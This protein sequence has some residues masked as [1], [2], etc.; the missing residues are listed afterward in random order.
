MLPLA[1][2]AVAIVPSQDVTLAWRLPAPSQQYVAQ[3]NASR[4]VSY[5]MNGVLRRLAGSRADPVTILEQRNRTLDA[6]SNGDGVYV[7]EVIL[8]RYGGEHPKDASV[9]KRSH[10][11]LVPAQAASRF[12][13]VGFSCGSQ[14]EEAGASPSP[15][16]TSTQAAAAAYVTC[17][18]A[19]D[20]QAQLYE[21]PGDAALAEFP[22]GP[23]K[24]GDSWTFSR[25]SRLERELAAGEVTYVDR[26]VRVEQRGDHRIAVL[27]VQATGRM[28]VV[29][30]LQARGFK[31]ATMAFKGIAEFDATSG[32]PQHQHYTGSTQWNTAILGAHLGLSIDETYDATPWALQN[33]P[34]KAQR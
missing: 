1:L 24:V 26:L 21:D 27:D 6:R 28:D 20:G 8:R 31:T 5:Q 16:A 7:A 17:A 15:A 10:R 11:E 23:I 25:R 13:P 3:S 9:K 12:S 19:K 30:D 32:V 4:T 2:L 14:D 33:A 34:A 18:A 29:K 22:A